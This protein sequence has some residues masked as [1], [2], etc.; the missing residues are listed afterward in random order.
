MAQRTE[1]QQAVEQRDV[2][3]SLRR[4]KWGNSGTCRGSQHTCNACLHDSRSDSHPADPRRICQQRALRATYIHSVRLLLCNIT[5]LPQ[6]QMAQE[7]WIER[8]L[9]RGLLR[10]RRLWSCHSIQKAC[11]V[12][13]HRNRQH[14][15]DWAACRV[16][17]VLTAGR[18]QV[19]HGAQRWSGVAI[20]IRNAG[21][22]DAVSGAEQLRLPKANI[23]AHLSA[24]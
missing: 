3:W 22:R 2:K 5:S 8:R 13:V 17:H 14:A 6:R 10:S 21:L 9:A 20:C 19:P 15:V 18:R 7:A 16:Q 1:A 4:G 12:L 24:A 23:A 11:L